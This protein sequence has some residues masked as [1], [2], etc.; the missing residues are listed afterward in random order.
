MGNDPS[1][2][3]IHKFEEAR[4]KVNELEDEKGKKA[5][6]YSG[7]KW[8]EDGEKPTKYF[9]SLC[10]S[11]NAKKQIHVLFDEDNQVI[12]GN[13]SILRYCK[14]HF[15]NIYTSR[16]SGEGTLLCDRVLG[17]VNFPRLSDA[18]KHLCDAPITAAECKKALDGMLNN[19]APSTSGFSK[20]FFLFFFGQS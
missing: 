14:S 5:M 20:K 2:E 10:A 13:D 12:T 4:R 6:L 7:A 19:K 11:R 15:Q 1:D 18:D 17:T 8:I 16:N 3:V 9:F